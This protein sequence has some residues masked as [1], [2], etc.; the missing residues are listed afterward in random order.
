MK[1]L[2]LK[3]KLNIAGQVFSVTKITNKGIVATN[4]RS[5]LELSLK[6]VVDNVCNQTWS[7]EN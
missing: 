2:G 6:E 7:V 5:V 3:S 4:G 1:L